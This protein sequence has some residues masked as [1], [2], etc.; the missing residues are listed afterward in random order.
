M[1]G[2]FLE[3]ETSF[4]MKCNMLENTSLQGNKIA[5]LWIFT[6]WKT[7][8]LTARLTHINGHSGSVTVTKQNS[9]TFA[10]SN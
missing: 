3:N 5:F 4:S 2:N 9:G 10:V 7:A 8:S 1:L 6:D